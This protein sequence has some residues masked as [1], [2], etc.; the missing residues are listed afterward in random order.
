MPTIISPTQLPPKTNK[1]NHQ[2]QATFFNAL[3][4]PHF[5]AEVKEKKAWHQIAAI[6]DQ[7]SL[8]GLSLEESKKEFAAP[9]LENLQ[10]LCE[11]LKCKRASF[12][13]YNIHQL[14][15]VAAPSQ[16]AHQEHVN[17]HF[18]KQ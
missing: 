1:P 14:C 13:E 18:K 17:A 10:D 12:Y 7:G 8:I 2:R 6:D 4:D 3:N 16:E 5:H 15:T 9:Y 11:Y